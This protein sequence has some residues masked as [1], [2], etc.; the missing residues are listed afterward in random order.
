MRIVASLPLLERGWAPAE[1]RPK[2]GKVSGVRGWVV[3]PIR[4]GTSPWAC[5]LNGAPDLEKNQIYQEK[6]RLVKNPWRCLCRSF[7]PQALHHP[8]RR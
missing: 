3:W 7:G 5:H 8:L 2:C 1:K 6:L 4:T